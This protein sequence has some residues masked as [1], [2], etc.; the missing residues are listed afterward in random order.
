MEHD[1]SSMIRFTGGILLRILKIA[2]DLVAERV[3]NAPSKI[4]LPYLRSNF[5]YHLVSFRERCLR[6]S[7]MITDRRNGV[8]SWLYQYIFIP[9]LLLSSCVHQQVQTLVKLYVSTRM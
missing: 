2:K 1:Y 9:Q 7:N 8:V 4:P 6:S 5:D 3:A